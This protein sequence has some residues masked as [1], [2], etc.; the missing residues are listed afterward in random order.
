MKDS[1]FNI[2]EKNDA[3]NEFDLRLAKDAM[4]QILGGREKFKMIDYAGR[5]FCDPWKGLKIIGK[6]ISRTRTTIA[7]QRNSFFLKTARQMSAIRTSAIPLSDA[8]FFVIRLFFVGL[9][10]LNVSILHL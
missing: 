1:I 8:C 3:Q 4:G 6:I 10:C 5:D 7:A 2:I 9:F